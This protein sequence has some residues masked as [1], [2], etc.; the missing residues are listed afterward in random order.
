MGQRSRS[1]FTVTRQR[2]EDA[3]RARVTLVAG[4]VAITAVALIV[5]AVIPMGMP[6]RAA[7]IYSVAGVG[8]LTGLVGPLL[9][10]RAC[11][12]ADRGVGPAGE[13]LHIGSDAVIVR[14][15]LRVPWSAVSEVSV[16]GGGGALRRHA[17]APLVGLIPRLLL[18]AGAPAGK[19]T[20]AISDVSAVAGARHVPARRRVE[21]PLGAWT[22]STE[23]TAAV[24]TFRRRLP[25][26]V[27][28]RTRNL[29]TASR[30]RG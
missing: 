27:P 4:C 9:L 10:W 19:V 18:R 12:R 24:V 26:A 20:I 3:H 29:P 21:V 16:T 17:H 23:M 7:I 2:R 14:G 15:D 1:T 6:T 22:G 25:A 28:V 8:L 30:T 13:L 11:T 5:C